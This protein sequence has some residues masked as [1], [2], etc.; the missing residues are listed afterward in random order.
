M[1]YSAIVAAWLL[2]APA[3]NASV[4]IKTNFLPSLAALPNL[5]PI[6]SSHNTLLVGIGWFHIGAYGSFET[7]SKSVTDTSY[8]GAIRFGETNYVELQGGTFERRFR[9]NSIRLTGKGFAANLIYGH[10]FNEY[11]GLSIIAA[12]K[13][14]ESGMNRRSIVDLVPYLTMRAGF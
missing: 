3:A 14:I 6:F 1:V 8:G 13:R 5:D 9:E 10:H 11:F 4:E 7:V 2:L 12:G